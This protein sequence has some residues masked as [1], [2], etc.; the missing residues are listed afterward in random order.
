VLSANSEHTEEHIEKQDKVLNS[1]GILII[2]VTYAIAVPV[3][4]GNMI[5]S[6]TIYNSG[7]IEKHIKK[8]DKVL[9]SLYEY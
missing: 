7:N 6:F 2:S 9:N 4:M 5:T 3:S 1:L 8:Q